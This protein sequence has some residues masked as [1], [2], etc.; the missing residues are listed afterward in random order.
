[1]KQAIFIFLASTS[2][3]FSVFA[4]GTDGVLIDPNNATTRD[5]SAVFQA[6]S[7]SQGVLV[8]RMTAAQRGAIPVNAARD[9]LMVDQT[10][11]TP[12]FYYYNGTTWVLIANTTSG[13]PPTGAAGGD[14]TGTYPNP[15]ITTNAIG[16]A[17]IT[18]GTITGTDVS[19]G[20]I[21]TADVAGLDVGDITSGV[22]PIARGGTNSGTALTASAIMVSNG[23]QI[24][25]GAAGTTTTVL[26]G[27]AAGVPTYG[28]IVSADITDGTIVSADIADGTIVSA[29]IADGTIATADIAANAV[30]VAKLP[31]GATGTT[32]LRGDGTWVVPTNSGGTVTSVATG[33]NGITGGTITSTGTISLDYGNTTVAGNGLRP[34]GN[35]G[36]FQLHNTYSDANTVPS[37]WGWNYV[38]GSTNTPNATSSQWYRQVV[39]LGSDYPARGAGGYSMELAF[40]R[41]S[42]STAGVWMRTVENGAIGGWSRIDAGATTY[43]NLAG[44]PTRTAWS[45][46]HRGFVAE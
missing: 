35:F 19:D 2:I 1:M 22:L 11:G 31:A 45:G 38:Q 17:E 43:A 10:D 28:P 25:Q 12:G 33:G 18:D 8:P 15:T 13:A 4:Q 32:F 21:G 34:Q 14:L 29:D 9:G 7:T 23:T 36:Q 46:V 39:S 41:F 44:I 16:S 42:A 5:A 27:N 37:Y 26:H 30:T 40:P 6:Q 20:S 3:S 24:V